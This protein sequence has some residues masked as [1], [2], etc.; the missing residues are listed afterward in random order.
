MIYT[1]SLWLL[2]IYIYI[3]TIFT[4]EY[5]GIAIGCEY[6]AYLN[7]GIS[8]VLVIPSPSASTT[9]PNSILFACI[10]C[11]FSTYNSSSISFSVSILPWARSCF[12][13]FKFSI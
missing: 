12:C 1:D 4:Y 5:I 6:I 13:L 8:S 2:D 9:S 11:P 10:R 3:Y 7:Y